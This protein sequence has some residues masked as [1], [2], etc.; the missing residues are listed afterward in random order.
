MSVTV[1]LLGLGTLILG[2]V[3]GWAAVTGTPLPTA[4]LMPAPLAPV[5]D[6]TAPPFP[7]TPNWA[8]ALPPN[9]PA[10]DP[11]T[12]QSGV[13]LTAPR[14]PL[15]KEALFQ[16]ANAV[17]EQLPNVS[18][19][20]RDPKTLRIDAVAVTRWLGFPDTISLQVI[21]LGGENA[22]VILF[23]RSRVGYSDLGANAR[24]IRAWMDL[25]KHS[26]PDDRPLGVS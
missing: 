7:T 16:R 13:I 6:L 21:P 12:T 24:R 23:S 8:L 18:V 22:S 10:P 19:I 14:Y 3:L 20:R 11:E 2:G 26:H 4:A 15:S 1:I 17:I 9:A 25:L 5:A